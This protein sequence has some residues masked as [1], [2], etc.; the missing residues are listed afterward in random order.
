M[1][2][3][4]ED[5]DVNRIR[6]KLKTTLQRADQVVN[7]TKPRIK[8]INPHEIY[9]LDDNNRSIKR[10]C[11]KQ[12]PNMPKGWVCL[13]PAGQGTDHPG[14]GYCS[15]H[16]TVITN[17]RNTGLW[18]HLNQDNGLPSNIRE[19]MEN[20]QLIEEQHLT[21]VDD[22]IRMMYVLKQ[23]LLQGHH[24]R[25]NAPTEGKGRKK[26]GEHQLSLETID[27]IL[28][29]TKEIV[30][31]KKLRHQLEREVKLDMSTVQTFVD[32]IF[33]VLAAEA[34]R[35]IAKKL[36]VSILEDVITP[37]QTA[38]RIKGDSFTYTPKGSKLAE[39]AGLTDADFEETMGVTNEK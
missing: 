35:P 29:I 31:T 1:N 3:K 33:K 12:R 20:A 10:I 9:L 27:M 28:K 11:G 8:K 6:G 36:M 24:L 38:G 37:L 18:Q 2:Q 34:P 39:K 16:D 22:D 25:V 17:S 15:S 19:L 7:S 32:Q 21:S 14:V 5:I 26:A 4:N 23:Y 30:S 13:Q